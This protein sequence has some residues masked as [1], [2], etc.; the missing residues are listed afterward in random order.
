MTTLDAQSYAKLSAPFRGREWIVQAIDKLLVVFTVI[1]YVGILAWTMLIDYPEVTSFS[2]LVLHNTVFLHVL[3]VPAV[4]F[5]VMSVA[6]AL[7]NARRPYEKLDIEPIMHK[8]TAGKSFP[9][10]HVFSAAVITM[11]FVYAASLG[12][13]HALPLAIAL[14]VATVL[15]GLMRVIGGVHF[16]RDVIWGAILGVACG[17]L[18]FW[19]F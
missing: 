14:G 5:I 7:I 16:P 19:V 3:L 18:G 15:I 4:S 13:E 12:I 1:A 11:A 6:R 8:E 2:H 9:G 17:A 10:R